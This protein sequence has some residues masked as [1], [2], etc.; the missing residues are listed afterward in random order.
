M[1]FKFDKYS[2]IFTAGLK[3]FRTFIISI[4]RFHYERKNSIFSVKRPTIKLTQ[5]H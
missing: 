2:Q 1:N 4:N 5:F 3:K